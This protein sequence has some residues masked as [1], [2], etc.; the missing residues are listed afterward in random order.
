MLRE[1]AMKGY[2]VCFKNLHLVTSWLPKL[3][4]EFK[5]L[6]AHENFRLLLTTEAH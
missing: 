1:G 3:E 4:K 2:W 5:S 6:D